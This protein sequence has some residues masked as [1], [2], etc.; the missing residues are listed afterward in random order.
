MY[1]E[2]SE[3]MKGEIK[4]EGFSIK[5]ASI[6]LTKLLE[7]QR[8]YLIPIYQRPY[9][10][11]KDQLR[12]FIG[13][14]RKNFEDNECMFIGTMQ[15]SE[16]KEIDGI[17]VHEIIDGQQRLTTIM[18]MI[19]VLT[20]MDTNKKENEPF[21]YDWLITKVN[22]GTEQEY[23]D[24]Y[25]KEGMEGTDKEFNNYKKNAEMIRFLL[26]EKVF[27]E[28][29]ENSSE[30]DESFS[31]KSLIDYLKEKIYFVVITTQ[32]GLTKTLQIFNS[33]NT[34]GMD[35][36]S[37][38]VFKI[39]MYEYLTTVKHEQDSVFNK[40]S[41][42][43]KQIDAEN[44]KIGREVC[45]INQILRIYQFM[46]IG[47]YDLPHALYEDGVERFYERLF[48]VLL[49]INNWDGYNNAK[50]AVNP[51]ELNLL[52]LQ[53]I[54]IKR[55]E[56]FSID[57]LSIDSKSAIDFIGWSRY[58]RYWFLPIIFNT[59]YGDNSKFEEFSVELMKLFL[60]YSIQYQKRV[61][62]IDTFI[63]KLI[64]AI[65]NDDSKAEE[66]I[67]EVNEKRTNQS[68]LVDITRI[69]KG[70]ITYN[71]KLKNLVCILA[72]MLDEK[73]RNQVNTIEEFK[74][75]TNRLFGRD[76]I[77]E[78]YVGFDIEH[79]HPCIHEDEN[80][81]VKDSEEWKDEINGIGNL[82]MLENH[83]NRSIK[84]T[85]FNEKKKQYDK[86]KYAAVE[87]ICLHNNWNLANAEERRK[88]ITSDLLNYLI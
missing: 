30:K 3:K 58:G 19:R 33:I 45:D 49:G 11:G 29:E 37:G 52:D 23:L 22:N 59:R 7:E 57:Y 75:I 64:K 72:A 69:F 87:K 80:M 84:N 61:H 54:L 9:A 38:D 43:Y 86:S 27:N 4:M 68:N 76:E 82:V 71:S 20:E 88:K 77:S 21:L 31:I 8:K 47:K 85:G 39:R 32:A 18:L 2:K 78:K 26:I 67:E 65:M 5:A 1:L 81:R 51:V 13:D 63:Y 62:E 83:I 17:K 66:I 70:G 16:P 42:I 46:I 6:N 28:I 50:S 73:E 60:I 40:I 12:R 36:N 25:F 24:S 44:K 56:L 15:R 48:D 55:F 14:I 79:I 74:Q 53:E 34:T 41:D 10:W 35:L